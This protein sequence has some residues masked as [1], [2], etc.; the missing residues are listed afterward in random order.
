MEL[1]DVAELLGVPRDKLEFLLTVK[2]TEIQG[3]VVESAISAKDALGV[4]H[5]LGKEVYSTVRR[6]SLIIMGVQD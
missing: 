4:C 1:T 3:Q 6:N 5:T 2:S